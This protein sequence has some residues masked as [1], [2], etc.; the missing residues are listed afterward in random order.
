MADFCIFIEFHKISTKKND[1]VYHFYLANYVIVVFSVQFVFIRNF[2]ILYGN[3]FNHCH[4]LRRFV[5]RGRSLPLV[6]CS[7][8]HTLTW[9]DL[10]LSI[11]IS[12]E[13]F[14]ICYIC[15]K[16]YQTVCRHCLIRKA[17]VFI[18][19]PWRVLFYFKQHEQSFS[20]ITFLL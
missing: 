18:Y 16:Y 20:L 6:Y 8:N 12:K 2:N 5:S 15:R 7:T 13:Y 3:Q 19:F 1:R 4:A 10:I 11:L 17:A 14:E 9:F